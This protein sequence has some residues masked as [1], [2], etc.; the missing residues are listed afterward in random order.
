MFYIIIENYI[1]KNHIKF[2]FKQ[3][4]TLFKE[5]KKRRFINS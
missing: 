5:Q 1:F 2:F 3:V 4:D